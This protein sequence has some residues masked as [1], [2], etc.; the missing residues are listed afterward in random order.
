VSQ[1]DGARPTSTSINTTSISVTVLLVVLG[2]L[3][4]GADITE[5]EGAGWLW[6]IL[7]VA[8]LVGSG[9]FLWTTKTPSRLEKGLAMAGLIISAVASGQ[10]LIPDVDEQVPETKP[11]A[12]ALRTP[13]GYSFALAPDSVVQPI[14]TAQ[15]PG[16]LP[17]DASWWVAHRLR[18]G[19]TPSGIYYTLEHVKPTADGQ[20]WSTNK[21]GIGQDCEQTFTLLLIAVPLEAG[22]ALEQVAGTFSL[23]EL[24]AGAQEK[25]HVNVRREPCAA[26]A[27]R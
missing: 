15:G 7:A 11:I 6:G 26:G 12:A 4:L 3:S 5:L 17:S 19:T 22:K 24:P 20:G 25:A 18:T 27:G 23:D 14:T 1:D 9:Y 2:V 21:F 10:L 13:G 8:A 16:A